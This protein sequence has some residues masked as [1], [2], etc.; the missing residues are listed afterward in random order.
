MFEE[1]VEAVIF[2]MDGTL[3][4]SE[5]VY[6]AGMQD[7]ARTLASSC[8]LASATRWSACPARSAM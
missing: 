8:R 3:L 7:A 2:D 4:D 6:I 5:T 1:P